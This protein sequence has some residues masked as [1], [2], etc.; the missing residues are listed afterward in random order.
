MWCLRCGARDPGADEKCGKCGNMLGPV[1]NRV[2]YFNQMMVLTGELLTNKLSL[3]DYE[4]TIQWATEAIDDMG[5]SLEPIEKQLESSNFD[6]LA[7]SL[8]KRPINSFR[9]GIETFHEGLEKLRFY[10]YEQNQ[11][12]LHQGLTLLEKANN[13]FNY[14]ADTANYLI[15]DI[16]K[17]LNEEQIAMV[18]KNAGVV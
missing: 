3:E 8:M 11:G 1:E 4:K 2:G 15:G 12:H 18:E 10:V 17:N 9:E 6:E 16:K 14:T 5:V 13:L 7:I